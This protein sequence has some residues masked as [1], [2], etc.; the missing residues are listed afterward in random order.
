MEMILLK[1][2]GS[3]AVASAVIAGILSLQVSRQLAGRR[4]GHSDSS[5]VKP[6]RNFFKAWF[7]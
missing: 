4:P 3:A 1:V 5:Q 2:M 6:N 7:R